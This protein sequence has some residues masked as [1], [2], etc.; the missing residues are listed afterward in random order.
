MLYPLYK[1]AILPEGVFKIIIKKGIKFIGTHIISLAVTV[2]LVMILS[3][4]IEKWGFFAFSVVTS[5]IYFALFYS[6]GWNWGRLEG[7]P[8]NEI[9][10]SPLRALKASLIPSI[11]PLIFT[12]LSATNISNPITTVIIK[13][14]YFPF[15]GFYNSQENI[16]LKEIL[17]SGA[18]L[19]VI[20]TIGYFIGTK[21]FSLLEKISFRK[22]K[23]KQNSKPSNS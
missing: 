7:R 6:D 4:L 15:I 21:N 9:K 23:S 19:P 8:Y 14:W 3:W 16:S 5:V 13:L 12:I 18:V 20:T 2:F 17:L 11:I 10:E 1:Y 22:R